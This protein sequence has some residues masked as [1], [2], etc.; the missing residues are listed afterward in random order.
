MGGYSRM[1]KAGMIQYHSL[2]ILLLVV[3]CLFGPSRAS[4]AAD[5]FYLYGT[6]ESFVWKEFADNGSRVVKE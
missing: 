3:I 6:V 2:R 4:R 5:D 1:K